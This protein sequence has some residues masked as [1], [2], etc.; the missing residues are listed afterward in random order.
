MLGAAAPPDP[1]AQNVLVPEAYAQLLDDLGFARQHVRLQVYG[2][3]LSS[4]REIVEWVKG[5]TLT[6][7]V[8]AFE[9]AEFER[10]VSEYARRLQDVLGDL[11]AY[12]YTFKRILMW[13]R[14]A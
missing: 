10:F 14:V 11:S 7:F 6:R 3:R 5:S 13:G 1:V 9:P 4:T 12:F 8:S 2:H